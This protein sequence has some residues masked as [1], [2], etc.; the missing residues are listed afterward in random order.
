M[1]KMITKFKIFETNEEEINNLLD[2]MSKMGKDSLSE[3]ELAVLKNKGDVP[4]QDHF[5]HGNFEFIYDETEDY[6]D[7]VVVKGTLKYNGEE[8]GGSFNY[9]KETAQNFWQFYDEDGIEFEPEP[10]DFYTLDSLM[11]DVEA[12]FVN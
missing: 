3:Y 8:Y 4:F 1:K 7:E 5:E 12:S 9:N 10:D 2:K 11:Q 6:G